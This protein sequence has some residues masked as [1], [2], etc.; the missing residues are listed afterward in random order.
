MQ[1]KPIFIAYAVC[2]I[3]IINVFSGCIVDDFFFGTSFTLESWKILDYKGFPGLSLSFSASNTVYV[4]TYDIYGDMIDEDIVFLDRNETFLNLASHKETLNSGPYTLKVLDTDDKVI[5]EKSFTFEGPKLTLLD[6]NQYWWQPEIWNEDYA[7]IGLTFDVKNI[8]DT[9]AYPF[10]IEFSNIVDAK[11]GKFIP[12]VILPG[13]TKQIYCYTYQENIVDDSTIEI[14]INDISGNILSNY[15]FISNQKNSVPSREFQWLFKGRQYRLRIPYVDLLYDYYN[16]LERILLEDYAL[17][18]FDSFDDEFTDFFVDRL[19][20][21]KSLNEDVDTIN[22]V[23]SFVQNLD[24]ISDEE[25]GEEVEYPRYPLETLYDG[26]SGGGDCE[27]KAILTASILFNMGYDVALLRLTNHMAVGVNIKKDFSA[28]NRYVDNYYFL[29]TTTKYQQLGYVPS[30]YKNDENLTV[31]PLNSRFLVYHQWDNGTISIFRNT[32]LG[33]FVRVKIYV[34]NIGIAPAE[35][36]IVTAGFFSDTGMELNS[37]SKNIGFL[38]CYG[39]EKIML[40]SILPEGA[41][42]IFKTKLKIN[43]E[44]V[45]EQKS[46]STFN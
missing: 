9:P 3:F 32:F 17:Y 7:L 6:C 46:A 29:E 43:G 22:F 27:D 1:K 19:L 40:V 33:D 28:Y 23:A 10:L 39:V 16:N 44:V 37:K 24:Y 8:G 12:S 42:T 35:D 36:V 14:R 25:M 41:T 31:F 5:F 45:D 20:Y 11:D 18:V 2:V 15:S 21:G 34:K 38:E 4:K 13:E 26:K 30:E